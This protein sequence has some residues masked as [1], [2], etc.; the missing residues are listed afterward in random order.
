MGANCVAL[1]SPTRPPPRGLRLGRANHKKKYNENYEFVWRN[2]TR[3]Q[4]KKKEKQKAKEK[5]KGKKEKKKKKN[6]NLYWKT[7]RTVLPIMTQFCASNLC[8]FG[9][10][11]IFA[12]SLSFSFPTSLSLSLP[13][14]FASFLWPGRIFQY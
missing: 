2:F 11:A 10:F 9:C 7:Q 3:P 14:L 8:L 4:R 5:P 1:Q 12:V 13:F 6:R